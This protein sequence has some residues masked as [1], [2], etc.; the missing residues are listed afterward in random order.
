MAMPRRSDSELPNDGELPVADA[1]GG[2]RDLAS[3]W[4]EKYGAADQLWSG[5]PNRALVDA[6]AALRTGRALDVGCGEGAD[7]VWLAQRGWD[8]TA[9]D[10]SGVALDRASRHA[11]DAGV[12]VRWVHAGLLE[13][14]LAAGTFDLVSAQYPVLLRTSRADAERTLLDAVAPEGVLI[15]VHHADFDP[16]H[17]KAQGFDPADYV[18]PSDVALLLDDN[19]QID[20]NE[21]RPRNVTTGGGAHHIQDVV[22]VARR[23]R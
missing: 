21:T 6:A 4:D 18:A 19:W 14:S 23:L 11:R 2:P 20:V 16:A 8:V 10:I 1:P 13:A 7:A 3:V 5:E 12:S 15:V 9:L 17:A 22:L